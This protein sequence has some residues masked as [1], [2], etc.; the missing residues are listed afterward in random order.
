M[1]DT[2]KNRI[3]A[4]TCVRNDAFFLDRWITYFGTAFGPKNLYIFQDGH[5]Q[6]RPHGAMADQVNCLY[7]PRNPDMVV[8]AE[9]RR[10]RT[11]S[12]LARGLHRHYDIVVA[13][14]VDE[15][16][17]LDPNAGSDLAEYLLSARGHS[18]IS[19]LGLDMVQ[20]MDK[21][22]PLDRT[23]PLLGQRRFAQVSSRYTKPV[24]SYRPVTWGAGMHRIK[25]RNFHIDPNLYLFHFGMADGDTV[26][27]R[28]N[29]P[30]L[31]AKGWGKH[32]QRR[33]QLFDLVRTE[34]ALDADTFLP[35]ARATQQK[36][37]QFPAWNKPALLKG[38]PVVEIPERFFGLV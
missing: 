12:A 18:T 15:F 32:M 23:A 21:E 16:L 6:E 30:D 17:V 37:R 4:I 20:H 14:D 19:G 10:A 26:T 3:A 33:M 36:R 34:Q 25:G 31:L 8:K 7:L 24:V 13:L 1:T 5:D 35:Q 9:K 27:A 11:I 2:A 29:D 28:A 38:S 22:P